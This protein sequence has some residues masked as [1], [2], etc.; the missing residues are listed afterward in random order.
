MP[1]AIFF[2]TCSRSV[3]RREGA[4]AKLAA[5][6]TVSAALC[7]LPCLLRCDNVTAKPHPTRQIRVNTLPRSQPVKTRIRAHRLGSG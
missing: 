2:A 6:S 3:T 4:D 5:Y 1:S 7:A